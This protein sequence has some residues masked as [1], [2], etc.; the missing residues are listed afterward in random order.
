VFMGFGG[1]AIARSRPGDDGWRELFENRIGLYCAS[2]R[3][4]SLS[5]QP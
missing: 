4:A 2:Q 3:E 1:G 5:A